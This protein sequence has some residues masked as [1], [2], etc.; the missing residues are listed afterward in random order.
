MLDTDYLYDRCSEHSWHD[1]DIVGNL[2]ENTAYLIWLN[3]CFDTSY[4]LN[5]SFYTPR[6]EV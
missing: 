2:Y 5:K 1:G 6:N 4:G 3:I